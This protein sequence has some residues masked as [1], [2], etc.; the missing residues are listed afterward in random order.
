MTSIAVAIPYFQRRPG[1]LRRALVSV[2]RQQLPAGVRIDI[3]VVDDGS[4]SPADGEIDGLAIDPP[5][6][7]KLVEQANA[8][9]GAA[10]NAAL[11]LISPATDYIAFLDS[12]DY[13]H[14][15]YLATALLA[16]GQGHDFFFCDSQ[17]V[18]QSFTSY[19][20]NNFVARFISEHGTPIGN[21]LYEIERSA[22]FDESLRRRV[23]R[24]PS[25]VYRRAVAPDLLFDTSLRVAGEDCLFF[26][27]LLGKCRRICCSTRLL[28]TFA[29]GVN[30]YAGKASWDDPGNLIRHMGILLACYRWREKLSLCPRND[31]FLRQRIRRLRALFA[32]LTIRYFLK[33][34]AGWPGELWKL[35]QSDARF[36]WWYPAYCAYVALCF[37]LRLYDPVRKW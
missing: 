25:T 7:I 22:F 27:Q 3:V 6:H 32:F 16:L 9:V 5:Y 26:F 36:R 31:L 12:D 37:P 21:D 20:E 30:I 33:K 10:R 23:F 15:E 8:G 17:R 29:D 24:T 14:P 4:T 34:R 18:G 35:V 19:S 11:D 1:I 13:W 28:A 2:L